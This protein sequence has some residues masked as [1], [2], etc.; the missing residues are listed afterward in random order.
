[1]FDGLARQYERGDGS[2]ALLDGVGRGHSRCYGYYGLAAA[3][4]SWWAR[5]RYVILLPVTSAIGFANGVGIWC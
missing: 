2:G 4:R 1:M 5:L 3:A